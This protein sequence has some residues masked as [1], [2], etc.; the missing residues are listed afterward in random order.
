M[1]ENTLRITYGAMLVAIFGVI[2]MLNR[3]TGGLFDSV[4]LFILPIPIVAYAIKYGGKASLAVF[5]CMVLV[6]FLLGGLTSTFYGVSAALIGLVYGTCLNHKVD[7][8]K[9]MLIV[10]VATIAVEMIDLVLISELLGYGLD[11]QIQEMQQMFDLA[12]QQYG[13]EFP[14]A[15]MGESSLMRI[16]LVA[17]GFSGALEG[18]VICGLTIVVLKKLR[19]P[20][21]QIS[22][23]SQLY[24]PKWT[25]LA[26]AGVWLWYSATLSQQA[27]IEQGLVDATADTLLNRCIQNE[28]AL[29]ATQI[30]G[31]VGYFY[32]MFFA[33]IAL[34]MILTKY[35]TRN[36]VLIVLLTFVG[37]FMGGILMMVLGVL[38]ISGTLHDRLLGRERS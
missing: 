16:A 11:V 33:I 27:A 32:L 31:M 18:F 1:R 34:S 4:M 36:K 3:Q 28:F 29:G 2:M 25:G 6:S 24:P 7:I 9:S 5:V 8:T 35:V 21:Q 15:I 30:I 12:A 10:V 22:P 19:I 17:I 13:V 26:A 37:F 14:S 20:V 38:Y 23:I